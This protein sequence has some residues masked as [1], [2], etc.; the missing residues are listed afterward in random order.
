MSQTETVHVVPNGVQ[1]TVSR[2]SGGGE[3]LGALLGLDKSPVR[4]L[5]LS[6]LEPHKGVEETVK[7]FRIMQARCSRLGSRPA[8]LIVAGEGSLS[9]RLQAEARENEFYVGHREPS[10][11]LCGSDV[12]VMPSER[13]SM[14]LAL[15]EAMEAG[16]APIVSN[17]AGNSETVGEATVTVSPRDTE[18]L[19]IEM[20][21]LLVDEARRMS[22]ARSAQERGR[23]K[24]SEAQMFEDTRRVLKSA[25]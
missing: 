3:E 9:N 19:A 8:V 10:Q 17:V 2:N 6:A 22:L 25:K 14:S 12:F 7:A 13:E 20:H 15:L 16:L 18:A 5:S 1:R 11:L 4:F 23:K 21:R 24:F